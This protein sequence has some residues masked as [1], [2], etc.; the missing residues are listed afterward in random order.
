M[1]SAYWTWKKTL[2][3]KIHLM[4]HCSS[5]S[6]DLTLG[7]P[8]YMQLLTTTELTLEQSTVQT[9]RRN[10]SRLW[11]KNTFIDK[12]K[13]ELNNASKFPILSTYRLFKQNFGLESHLVQIKNSLHRA[14]VNKIRCSSHLLAIERGRHTK[15][16]TPIE[17]RL[18]FHCKILE[19]EI[20]FLVDCSLYGPLRHVLLNNISVKFPNF[21]N[22]QS[23]QKLIFLLSFEDPQILGHLGTLKNSAFQERAE[24]LKAWIH[25]LYNPIS[26]EI[27]ER[28]CVYICSVLAPTFSCTWRMS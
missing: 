13:L 6:W 28:L 22:L 24:Y 23:K 10:I 12:W 21:I 20:H 3:L 16:E 11:L 14:A 19:D 25:E 18:C 5:R 2:F 17:D 27:C 9:N 4:V 1:P 8:K 7:Y 15:P 26:D